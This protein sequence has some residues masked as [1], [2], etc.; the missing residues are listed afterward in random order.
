MV[1][2][3][4]LGQQRTYRRKPQEALL[5][6]LVER[7]LTK[8]HILQM[9]LNQD[10]TVRTD[11]QKFAESGKQVATILERMSQ[12]WIILKLHF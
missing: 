1:R 6:I 4:Y 9:Y 2:N 7:K 10:I 12:S 5:A 11:P 3:F 8:D